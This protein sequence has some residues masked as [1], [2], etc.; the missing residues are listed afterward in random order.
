M[1]K[2]G[3]GNAEDTVTSG[4]EG[5]WTSTPTQWDVEY[6]WNLFN[7]EWELTE[8]PAGGKQWKPANGQAADKV[9]DAHIE[10]KQHAPMMLTSDLALREDP[11][12]APIARRFLDNPEQLSEAFAKAWY[13]LTHRDLGPKARYLGSEVPE[14]DMLWQDPIP[15][16]DHELADV[17]DIDALKAKILDSGVGVPEL[18][19]TAWSSASTFRNSDKR[20]GANGA[21]IRLA[22]MRDWEVNK[23]EQLA[24]VLAK[25]EG[26]QSEFNRL[27]LRRQTYFAR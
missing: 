8:S 22:P 20:G 18:V 13:K 1:N 14:G 19:Y 25:L 15:A 4:I 23:P 2:A 27:A 26:I 11:E 21:R 9:P 12:Y 17:A 10:G 6:L 24:R 16:V 7:Y 5:A 3:R